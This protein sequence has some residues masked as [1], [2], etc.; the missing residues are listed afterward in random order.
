VTPEQAAADNSA[1]L[2]SFSAVCFMTVRDIARQHTHDRPMGLVQAAWG[3]SRLESW[4]SAEALASAGAPV[5]NNKTSNVPA[6]NNK[7]PKGAANNKSYLYNGMVSP[8]A[9]FSIRAVLW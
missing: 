2:L 9:N 1:F 5:N 4:M 3:G 8:W 6:N 7:T